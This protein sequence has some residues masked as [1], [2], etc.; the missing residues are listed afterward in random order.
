MKYYIYIAIF[1]IIS[2]LSCM[3]LING[4]YDF[5]NIGMNMITNLIGMCFTIFIID[6]LIRKNEATKNLKKQKVLYFRLVRFINKQTLFWSQKNIH[7]NMS[8]EELY[9][10]ETFL[11]IINANNQTLSDEEL[12]KFQKMLEYIRIEGNSIINNN[13]DDLASDVFEALY[14][15]SNSIFTSS[16][17]KKI[18]NASL[19]DIIIV[20]LEEDFRA[21]K[22]IID[23]IRKLK[24]VI[25]KNDGII[26]LKNLM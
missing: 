18:N 13:G 8:I 12:I 6:F 16:I 11:K 14:I 2:C 15:I 19:A 21:Y 7:E 5:P 4:K 17:H 26:E 20:P 24:K 23:Y 9:T 25:G 1:F 3:F 22:T 10:L